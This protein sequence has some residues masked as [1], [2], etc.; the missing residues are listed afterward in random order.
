MMVGKGTNRKSMA[1]IKNIAAFIAFQLGDKTPGYRVFNYV[2]TPDLNMNQLVE[3]VEETLEKKNPPIRLP[4]W[5][6]MLGGYGFDMI[7]K[8]TGKKFSISSVRVKKFCAT[9][10]FD[11]KKAHACGFTAPY[12]LIQGLQNTLANEFQNPKNDGVIFQTE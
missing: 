5:L 10:Q 4:Y 7:G 1:Y 11:A 6:G 9:T 3:H 8:I 12:S 2:D